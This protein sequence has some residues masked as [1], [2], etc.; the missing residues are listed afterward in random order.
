MVSHRLHILHLA[1]KTDS[2]KVNKVAEQRLKNLLIEL[3]NQNITDFTIVEG[4]YDPVNTKQAIQ[5]GHKL[6]AR[7]AKE[8][9][10][11]MVFIGEDDLVFTAKG[12]WQYFISQVPDDFDFFTALIYA[13]EVDE[14]NRIRNGMSGTHTLYVLNQRFY[15]VVLNQPDDVHCDRNLG[16][17]AYQYK[18]YVCHKMCITQRGGY[19]FNLKKQMTYEPYIEGKNMFH[20]CEGQNQCTHHS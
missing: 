6:I 1:A 4:F 9:N 16:Q 19:S 13:G 17:L 2:D 15:D 20:G 10:M 12:A 7:L 18:Y 8:Q 11:P 3:D 14:T 5:R